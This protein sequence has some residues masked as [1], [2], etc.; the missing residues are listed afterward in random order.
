[1]RTSKVGAT[2]RYTTRGVLKSFGRARAYVNITH[3]D[4][5]GY[6]LAMTMSFE[7]ASATQLDGL[8][9]GDRVSFTFTDDGQHRR[10]EQI[11]KA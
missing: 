11:T 10:L 3:E 6:M 1:M 7:P 8:A 9:E 2:E 5:P 4:I